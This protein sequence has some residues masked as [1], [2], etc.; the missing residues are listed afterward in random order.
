MRLILL[1]VLFNEVHT[2]N[3]NA[4]HINDHEQGKTNHFAFGEEN[5]RRCAFVN[6]KPPV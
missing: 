4:N 5:P 1:F 3:I 2:S 6:Q